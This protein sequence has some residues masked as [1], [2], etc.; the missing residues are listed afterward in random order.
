MFLEFWFMFFE[1]IGPETS[2]LEIHIF[3]NIFEIWI[4][5]RYDFIMEFIPNRLLIF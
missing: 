3:G 2:T 1:Y 4:N 5:N